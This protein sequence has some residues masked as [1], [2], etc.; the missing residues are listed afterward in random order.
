MTILD[1]CLPASAD[2]SAS[3]C[4]LSVSWRDRSPPKEGSYQHFYRENRVEVAGVE[5]AGEAD[6]T[7]HSASLLSPNKARP[8]LDAASRCIVS[9]TWL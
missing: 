5:P 6:A 2:A 4:V 8:I 3:W 7:P 9:V 1:R